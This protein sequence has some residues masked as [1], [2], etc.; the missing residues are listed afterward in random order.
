MSGFAA[1]KASTACWVS[2]SRESL[3][4]VVTRS[5]GA[6]SEPPWLWPGAHAAE[7]RKHSS[8]STYVSNRLRPE[9]VRDPGGCDRYRREVM[10]SAFLEVMS[11]VVGRLRLTPRLPGLYPD[12]G[13]IDRTDDLPLEGWSQAVCGGAPG[14]WPAGAQTRGDH[15]GRQ[16]TIEGVVEAVGRSEIPSVNCFALDGRCVERGDELHRRPGACQRGVVAAAG[17][18]IVD[19]LIDLSRV[20]AGPIQ[21]GGGGPDILAACR[22]STS[23]AVA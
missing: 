9:L 22:L 14:L 10:V 2:L 20:I 3:P 23:G 13:T 7:A 6:P 21:T 4:Q 1:V 5:S 8:R 17:E 12:S 18:Q 16:P 19:Q 11:G 15:V